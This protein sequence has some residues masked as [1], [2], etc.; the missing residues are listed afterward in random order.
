MSA[1]SLILPADIEFRNQLELLGGDGALA[2]LKGQSIPAALELLRRS[3]LAHLHPL[4][5]LRRLGDQHWQVP[6]EN[7]PTSPALNRLIDQVESHS[8]LRGAVGCLRQPVVLQRMRAEWLYEMTAGRFE[9]SVPFL[10]NEAELIKAWEEFCRELREF[11]VNPFAVAEQEMQRLPELSESAQRLHRL[12]FLAACRKLFVFFSGAK[13]TWIGACTFYEF[14]MPGPLAAQRG[15]RTPEDQQRENHRLSLRFGQVEHVFHLA[16]TLEQLR[17]YLECLRD[18][19]LVAA[20]QRR[21]CPLVSLAPQ[22]LNSL[23]EAFYTTAYVPRQTLHS[24][25]ASK[26]ESFLFQSAMKPDFFQRFGFLPLSSETLNLYSEM[27]ESSPRLQAFLHAAQ[28]ESGLV[29][30]RVC[31]SVLEPILAEMMRKALCLLCRCWNPLLRT[32]EG[33]VVLLADYVENRAAS[34]AGDGPKSA[35]LR[36]RIVFDELLKILDRNT[37]SWQDALA[38]DG[39]VAD[40][41]RAYFLTILE[42]AIEEGGNFHGSG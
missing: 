22:E 30:Q 7:P 11:S 9:H 23:A 41:T 37:R 12:S 14:E 8:C 16:P 10:K 39:F 40:R 19:A 6:I 5:S 42:K 38:K 3:L 21:L 34:L 15:G 32:Q 33:A 29:R 35:E 2:D 31:R 36:E 24:P 17:L 26:D 13:E 27:T 4:E 20:V 28:T 1:P 18:H 25:E